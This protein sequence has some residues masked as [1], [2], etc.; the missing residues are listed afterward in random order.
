MLAIPVCLFILLL[1]ET[2]SFLN[3]CFLF[4]IHNQLGLCTLHSPLDAAWLQ[5]SLQC[6]CF[7]VPLWTFHLRDIKEQENTNSWKKSVVEHGLVLAS[8]A[9]IFL[10]KGKGIA[11]GNLKTV[12]AF[13]QI[14]KSL[15]WLYVCPLQLHP[16]LFSQGILNSKV[17][18]MV[19]LI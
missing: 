7:P 1:V 2:F 19:Y 6:S 9:L 13:A 16:V 11:G 12:H 14:R 3:K 10:C 17:V 4:S 5:F 8:C 15:F 18:G